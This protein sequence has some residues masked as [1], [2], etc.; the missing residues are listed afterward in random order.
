MNTNMNEAR[1]SA[2][3]SVGGERVNADRM[4]VGVTIN[5]GVHV[6]SIRKQKSISQLSKGLAQPRWIRW[7][8]IW[9]GIGLDWIG[10]N[11]IGLD[12]I[13]LDLFRFDWI[14]LGLD[15]D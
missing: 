8:W 3:A 6:R 1:A 13:R 4:S 12:W 5:S 11:W 2:G 15:L 7:D 9:I 14:G 10:L